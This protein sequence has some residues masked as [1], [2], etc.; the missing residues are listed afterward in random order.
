MYLRLEFLKT[1][2]QELLRQ[3]FIVLG[4]VTVRELVHMPG[5]ITAKAILLFANRSFAI[6]RLPGR[7]GLCHF[8]SYKIT[9]SIKNAIT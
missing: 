6:V 1:L 9:G 3:N 8:H 2:V 4:L 5:L 7:G